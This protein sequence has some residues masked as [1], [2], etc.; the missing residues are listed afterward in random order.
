MTTDQLT[1]VDVGAWGGIDARWKPFHDRIR[2]VAFEPNK[3]E[4]ERLNA[5]RHDYPVRYFPAA[6]GAADGRRATLHITR[7]P[8]CSSL[9][10][11]S[12]TIRERF[13]YARAA[14]EIVGTTPVTLSSLDTICHEH[15]IKPDVIKI[16]VQGAELDVL[17]GA[18]DAL[19]HALVVE[20]E[21]E[22]LEMY[23]AQ[24]LAWDVHAFMAARGFE[25]RAYKL[26][27]WRE[28]HDEPV[29][30]QG[31]QLVHGDA[32][33]MRKDLQPRPQL[34]IALAAYRQFD[35]LGKLIAGKREW[36]WLLQLARRPAWL[37]A[38]SNVASKLGRHRDLRRMIDA[39]CPPSVTDWHDPEFF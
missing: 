21:V 27:H 3:M 6:L 1:L 34:Y 11:P 38:A 2:V 17:R 28:D 18:H 12:E 22:F 9:Y 7:N 24:P 16:D 13:A 8:Q 33:Y 23:A 14:L 5:E 32:L 31:G 29:S 10:R 35:L 19:R 15:A 36:E 37:R 26:T 20:L 4:C 25:L 39:L 30:A